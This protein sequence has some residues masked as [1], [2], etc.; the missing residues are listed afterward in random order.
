MTSLPLP[1]AVPLLLAVPGLAAGAAARRLLARL[2][3]GAR[4]P[5]PWCELGVA[6]A[7][8]ASGRAVAVGVVPVR[9]LPVLLGLGW[10]AVAAA[11]VDL[12]HHRLPD[13]LTLPA[14]PAAAL[15]LAPLGPAAVLR[16]LAGA[17]VAF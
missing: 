11:V 1:L 13:A 15:L 17:A 9:W 12:V 14:L 5:P 2:R 4:V 3:R 6:F 16:G 7:W 10:L 8:A